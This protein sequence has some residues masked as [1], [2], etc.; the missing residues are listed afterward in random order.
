MMLQIVTTIFF[1]VTLPLLMN[2]LKLDPTVATVPLLTALADITAI[3]IL[4]GIFT[5]SPG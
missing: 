1:G 2:R 5:P 4:F 3:I